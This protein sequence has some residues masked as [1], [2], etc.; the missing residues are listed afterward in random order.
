V[1]D[2]VVQDLKLTVRL[3]IA[4]VQTVEVLEPAEKGEYVAITPAPSA[5]LFPAVEILM[6]TADEDQAL[7]ELEPPSTRPRGHTMLR[8]AV[9]SDGSVGN[10]R[11]KRS[12][13]KVRKQPT[14]SFSQ[15][16]RRGRPPPAAERG[17]PGPPTAGWQAHSLP[18]RRR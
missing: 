5:G 17:M 1:S 6:L 15:K 2:H 10:S 4:A 7:I 12:S 3:R 11:E 9:P 13:S 8:P 14:G 16:L 18:N